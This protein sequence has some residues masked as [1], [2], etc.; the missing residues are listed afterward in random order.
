MLKSV[1]LH[2]HSSLGF[3]LL[4]AGL[5]EATLQG[6]KDGPQQPLVSI[7]H[8]AYSYSLSLVASSTFPGSWHLAPFD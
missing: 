3:G 2:L 5:M 8:G 4:C 6:G 1:G 7:I